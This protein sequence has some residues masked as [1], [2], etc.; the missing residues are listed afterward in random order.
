M[1]ARAERSRGSIETLP[2]G[3][4]RVRALRRLRPGDQA[5]TISRDIPA[6]PYGRRAPPATGC[7]PRSRPQPM[8]ERR[9]RPAVRALP[10][11]VR[12]RREHEDAVSRLHPQTHLALPRPAEGRGARC[13]RARL[14]LRRAA[15]LSQPLLRPSTPTAARRGRGRRWSWR[16]R[17]EPRPV[18]RGSCRSAGCRVRVAPGSRSGPASRRAGWV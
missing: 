18:W 14:V 8:N 6:G 9:G 10:R 16:P 7:S 15:A 12:R 1:R 17:R 5:G 3:A 11:P 4:L 13:G 2:S